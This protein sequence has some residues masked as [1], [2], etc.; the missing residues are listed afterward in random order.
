M[1]TWYGCTFS[2]KDSPG[3]TSAQ[4]CL[5]SFEGKE[6]RGT[7]DRSALALITVYITYFNFVFYTRGNNL[8][9][10]WHPVADRGQK[11]LLHAE[12]NVKFFD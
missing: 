2:L 7:G 9:F 1:A 4:M 5:L 10:A 12:L 8:G 11:I 3:E 6:F